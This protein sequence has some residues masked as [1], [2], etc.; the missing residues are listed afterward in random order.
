[1]IPA[2]LSMMKTKE[3]RFLLTFSSHIIGPQFVAAITVF[4]L[5]TVEL[6]HLGS[7]FEILLDPFQIIYQPITTC[8][9]KARAVYVWDCCSAVRRVQVWQARMYLL[10]RAGL[11]P[12]EV[13]QGDLTTKNAG[14]VQSFLQMALSAFRQRL[15]NVQTG[16]TLAC[17]LAPPLTSSSAPWP[18]DSVLAL[19]LLR[20]FNSKTQNT[21]RPMR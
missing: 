1:M 5:F 21:N 3:S 20:K 13:C 2:L 8:E 12:P 11:C 6:Q 7:L 15:S 17:A 16:E 14:G 19:E 4:V 18:N 9:E 10:Y